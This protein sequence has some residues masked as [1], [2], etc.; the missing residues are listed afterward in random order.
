MASKPTDKELRARVKLLGNL[1]GN[2]LHAQAGGRVLKAVEMLRKGYIGLRQDPNPRK[3]ARLSRLTA[4]LDALTLTHVVR[5][6]STYFSLVNIAEEAHQHRGRRAQVRGGGPL[7]LGSFDQTLRQFQAQGISVEQLQTLLDRLAYIPVITAH[8]TESKRQTIMEALRR[9]F[10]T[11]E[12][13]NDSRLGK[14]ERQEI[15]QLLEAQIQILWKTDEV[16]ATRPQVRDEIKN[17]LVYFH[18]CLFQAVPT[19]YRYLEK[20]VKKTYGKGLKPGQTITVP[21]FL[22]FGSWIG[23]DR[24]GNPNVKPETTLLALRRQPRSVLLEYLSRIIA[25]SRVLTHSSQLCQPSQALRDSLEIDEQFCYKTFGDNLERFRYE[26]YRRKLYV[27]RYRLECNLRTVKKRIEGDNITVLEGGYGA[28]QELLNDLYLIRDSLIS[29]GDH[30]IAEAELQDLIRLVESFGFF[31]LRLDVR[32]ESSRHTQAAAELFSRQSAN[33]DYLALP[34]AGRMQL[35]ASTIRQGALTAD[36]DNLIAPTQESLAVFETMPAMLKEGGAQA[37][38]SYVISMTHCASHVLEVML[39]ACQAG[40]AGKTQDDAWFCHLRIAPLFETID[41]LQRIEVVL[42]TLLENPVYAELLKASGN[43]Q[44]VMLGYSD[45][46]KDGGILA[47]AWML[48]Q[49]QKKV[50]ALTRAHGI[51]CQLFHGRGGTIG[52]GGGPTHESILAQPQGTVHGPIKFTEQ[53]EVLTYKYSNWETAVYELSVG[54]TGLMKASRSLIQPP[55]PDNAEY[56]QIMGE[57][58]ELGEQIYRDLTRTPGFLDYFYEATPI[59]EIGQLNIGSRPPPP[60]PSDRSLSSIR[61]IAWVF[62]WAQSRHTLPAW[63]GIGSAL[64]QWC[65]DDPVRFTKLQ[66]M[67]KDWPFFRAL[68]SNTQMALFQADMTIAH[69]YAELCDDIDMSRRIYQLVYD[70]YQRTVNQVLKVAGAK[71]LIEDNPPLALSLSR[72]NP[73]LDPLNA[74]Q[75]TLLERYRDN[76]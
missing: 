11:S 38:G 10:I 52:R 8:P 34:E 51:E 1:L 15:T 50:T 58:A 29:H 47:S 18:E 16:R 30:S 72:R 53:G 55:T 4:A 62:G 71:T 36:K 61:A 68:L 49:A 42:A 75:V 56:L 60:S 14:G 31:L 39:L 13:L 19:M 69:D 37:F 76:T 44:E 28:A 41:D 32:Q 6:F 22:R 5:A 57:L 46:C 70:E 48:Y 3:R 24:D 26:P 40:L 45:S 12:R 64:Q 17:G 59:N 66:A 35:L 23:G 33:I 9:I 27:I 43:Q 2:V 63:Y 74:I 54:V 73:Y 65:G 21:S 7:W 20:A 67:Y 25:L